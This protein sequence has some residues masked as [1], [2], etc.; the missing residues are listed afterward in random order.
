MRTMRA[1]AW[2]G[3]DGGVVPVGREGAVG[4]DEG[5]VCNGHEGDGR[6]GAAE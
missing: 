2:G 1:G 4:G 3:D 6:R 5:E